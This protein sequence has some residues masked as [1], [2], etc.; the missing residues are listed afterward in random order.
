MISSS[1]SGRKTAGEKGRRTRG[2]PAKS[3]AAQDASAL[4]AQQLMS[5]LFIYTITNFFCVARIIHKVSVL[6][7]YDLGTRCGLVRFSFGTTALY[8]HLCARSF[9]NSEFTEVFAPFSLPLSSTFSSSPSPG[10]VSF[11]VPTLQHYFFSTAFL[12]KITVDCAE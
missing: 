9:S 12:Y 2:V 4:F 6:T 10:R 5:V 8:S 3:G 11:P 7:S 1:S